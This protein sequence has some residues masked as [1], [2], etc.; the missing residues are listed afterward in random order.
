MSA[1]RRPGLRVTLKGAPE[2]TG[3][4]GAVW[5]E[6]EVLVKKDCHESPNLVVNEFIANR[7]AQ[8]IGVPVP[9]GD[10]WTDTGPT[11]HWV[12]GAVRDRGKNL[13]PSL[14][15]DV[16]RIADATRGLIYCFDALI[17][18]TDRHLDNILIDGKG[19]AWLID[20]DQ[21]LF[22]SM[23]TNRA[24]GLDSTKVRR[25]SDTARIW[26]GDAAPS[27]AAMESAI[28]HIQLLPRQAI[29]A[30]AREAQA[31]G[32]INIAE[33]DAVNNFL[34]HR[35]AKIKELVDPALLKVP[36]N[37]TVFGDLFTAMQEGDD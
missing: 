36:G 34:S 19:N 33:R 4:T 30:P 18:N 7:L 1:S 28:R 5:G 2:L 20:H 6:A 21:A 32:Y 11:L 23:R 22:G 12:I 9:A 27:S 17:Y 16:A 8:A 31:R 10:T 26:V 3:T 35:Q 24:Q 25:I 29:E 37:A 15:S 14:A 13:P